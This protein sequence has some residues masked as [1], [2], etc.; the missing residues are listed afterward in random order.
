MT[1]PSEA[2]RVGVAIPAA[3]SGER[4]G[5]AAKAFLP[6]AGEPL[7]L[8]SV[9]P[10]LDHPDVE[11]V[12]IALA[13]EYVSDPPDWLAALYPR[14][15][16]VTGGR[17]RSESVR[18]SIG[19]L[20]PVDRVLVHDAARPLVTREIIDRCLEAVE[21]G[22]GA[23]AG[24]PMED[25]V[26]E[27]DGSGVVVRTL[28]RSAMWRAQTPQ[29]FPGS[30]LAAAYAAGNVESATDDAEVF[31]RGGGRVRMVHGAPW[32]IKITRPD[33]LDMAELLMDRRDGGEKG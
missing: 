33:D 25:T 29:A 4:M 20:G 11:A 23:I 26:K 27:V 3:G 14:V 5:R 24:W 21:E 2:L 15:R 30:E 32:N 7:L 13:A 16:L 1:P 6:L 22:V 17:T 8:R 31:Q 10:F 9:R 18:A 28:D 19:V 12:A